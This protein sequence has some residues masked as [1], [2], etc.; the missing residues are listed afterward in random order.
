MGSANI[1]DFFDDL[2]DCRRSTKNMR[3]KFIDIITIAICGTISGAD[4]WTSVAQYGLTKF[5]WFK[6]FLEL[7]N[8]IPS[9]DTFND[10]FSKIDTEVFQNCFIS[11]ISSVARLLPDE[12][13]AID[14]KTLRRSHDTAENKKAIHVVS[15]YAAEASLVLGQIVTAE[16]SNEITAIPDLIDLL[17]IKGCLVT[18]DAMGCQ[19][20]IAN[21][22]Q[23][24][25]AD[26]LLAVKDNQPKL[27]DVIEIMFDR[28]H[29]DTCDYFEAK[30]LGHGRIAS[31]RCWVRYDLENPVFN[32]W[33]GVQSVVMIESERTI[34]NET[35]L[36]HR[37][38]ISSSCKRNAEYFLKSTQNHWAIEN[39][40]HWVLD[41][42][43]RE[44]EARIRK[45]NGAANF[46][47]LR[48]IAVNLIKHEKTAK[49]GVKIKRQMA[50]WDNSYLKKVLYG[51]L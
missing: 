48:H 50:G 19:N 39:K 46:S 25:D 5:E 12:V 45:G 47:L 51:K 28:N 23:E 10:V 32:K 40:L 16:K 2:P 33:K 20:K 9:H 11:W 36:E 6:T 22:I 41:V 26:Y 29:E 49:V 17:Q 15:A 43:F 3:H 42:A 7:P 34:N 8:G 38:Y 30:D 13:V 35:S 27:H 21:K 31:R 44:D 4:T 24:K 14:G 37:Y 1:F 18:I